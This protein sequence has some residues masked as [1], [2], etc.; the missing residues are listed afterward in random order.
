MSRHRSA[1]MAL[2]LALVL[3]LASYLQRAVVVGC[4][5][6]FVVGWRGCDSMSVTQAGLVAAEYRNLVGLMKQAAVVHIRRVRQSCFLDWR[7]M[8][9]F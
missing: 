1:L 4:Y 7:A 9:S 8:V 3:A 6:Q 5:I 2:A